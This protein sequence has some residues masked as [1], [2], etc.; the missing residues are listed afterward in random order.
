M[1]VRREVS[2]PAADLRTIT[3]SQTYDT[4]V[5]DLWAACTDR[6][7]LSRW[8]L[9]V[10]GDLRV[11]GT[12]RLTNN[13]QGTVEHCDP[14]VAFRATWE[15][16]GDV[17]SVEVRFTADPA[18]ARLE[19][20][21]RMSVD[22]QWTE[23]GPGAPGVGWEIGLLRLRHH[24]AGL[25]IEPEEVW[26]ATDEGKRFMADAAKGWGVA[27]AADGE[28]PA[29]AEAAAQRTAKGYGAVPA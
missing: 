24:V 22:A 9:P 1:N 3:I 27:H 21:H 13:V 12:Y 7:R 16:E 14:P 23:Y 28:D 8:F 25:P 18:G 26:V 10:E 17:S 6:D 15:Y 11:G 4:S 5:E 19:L 2:S 20:V 29:I